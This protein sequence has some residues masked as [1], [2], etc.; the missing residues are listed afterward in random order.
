MKQKTASRSIK[1]LVAKLGLDG[2]DRGALVLCRAFRDAGMEVIYSGLFA[3]PERI[4]QITEDEATMPREVA[5]TVA[6]AMPTWPT[7]TAHRPKAIMTGT[8]LGS[9]LRI[10]MEKLRRVM[11][12]MPA[13]RRRA[14]ALPVS[15]LLMLRSE[16]WENITAAPVASPRMEAGTLAASQVSARSI[17]LRSW[18]VETSPTL[19]V[20]RLARNTIE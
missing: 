13:I 7:R 9:K 17:R 5:E 2:H 6:A 18:T 19:A 15:M 3:T 8:A 11:I 4:A 12:M 20:T 16:I 1:I 10:P 14:R